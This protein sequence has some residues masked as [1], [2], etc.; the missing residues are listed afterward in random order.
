[1]LADHELKEFGS[2][3]SSLSRA[4]KEYSYDDESDIEDDDE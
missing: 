3:D 4:L 1:M 2:T